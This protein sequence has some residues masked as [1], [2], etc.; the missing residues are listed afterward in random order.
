MRRPHLL[1]EP[2]RASHLVLIG[3]LWIGLP[4]NACEGDDPLG[5]DD[6]EEPPIETDRDEYTIE[7]GSDGAPR[8]RVEWTFRNP[9]DRQVAFL[10]CGP[11]QELQKRV[12]GVWRRVAGTELLCAGEKRPLVLKRSESFSSGFVTSFG[13]APFVSDSVDFEEFGGPEGTY[14]L[15]LIDNPVIWQENVDR[16]E[17]RERY[18]APEPLRVSNSFEVRL[19]ER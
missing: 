19:P 14:R 4:F 5:L 16:A 13:H 10:L 15:M 9:L 3:V 18:L 6:L 11:V 17:L 7:T 1:S 2:G 12:E 8:L